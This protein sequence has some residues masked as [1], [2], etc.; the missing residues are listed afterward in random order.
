MFDS[1]GRD[2][3]A[4]V[5]SSREDWAYV[6]IASFMLIAEAVTGISAGA[7]A[8]HHT[9]S[10]AESALAAPATG[11]GEYEK[12][13]TI[14]EKAAVLCSR[15]VRNHPLPDGNKRTAFLCMLEFLA[16]N[17]AKWESSPNDPDETASAIEK[18][19]GG[20]FSEDRMVKFVRAR[21]SRT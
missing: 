3:T 9:I 18:L 14:E 8:T 17:G 11:F 13:P 5:D 6:D 4:A 12:Y 16:L 21:I 10:R 2:G 20:T 1:T 15:I 7:L 19:A